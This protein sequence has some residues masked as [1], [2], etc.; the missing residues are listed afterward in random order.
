M[1]EYPQERQERREAGTDIPAYFVINT[2]IPHKESLMSKLGYFFAGVMAGATA[3][4][5]AA[6]WVDDIANK[7]DADS[8]SD[9]ELEQEQTEDG[10]AAETAASEGVNPAT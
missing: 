5:A 4:A 3:L 9:E 8:D 1:T 10:P 7:L 2:V 6:F